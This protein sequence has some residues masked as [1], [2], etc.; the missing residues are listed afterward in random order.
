MSTPG[1]RSEADRIAAILLR[2]AAEVGDVK[3]AVPA[4][5]RLLWRRVEQILATGAAEIGVADLFG[6]HRAKEV[7]Q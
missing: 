2:M 4:E 5:Q 6:A 3:R 7:D 1:P